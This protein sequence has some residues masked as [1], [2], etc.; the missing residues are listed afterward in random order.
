MNT[1]FILSSSAISIG[2]IH[3]L[4]G[5]DHYLPF[6]VMAKA[7]QW[8]LMKTTLITFF[9]GV[10]H[11]LSA[12]I[13]GF[14]AISL[15]AALTHLKWIESLRGEIA[16]WLLIGFGL[17]YFIWGIKHAIKH[18]RH[19]H[20]HDESDGHHHKKSMRE[21]TPWI[22]FIIFILGPCE[23]LIPLVMYPAIKGSYLGV[24]A[25]SICFGLATLSVML[26][27]VLASVTGM[28]KIKFK[29]FAKYGHVMAG[30]I[31]CGSGLAIKFLG[32]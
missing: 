23:P 20:S 26:S 6:I 24:A 17:A 1:L 11:V 4:L 18:G 32:L 2:F 12:V 13:L 9:C 16:A 7:R 30:S 15:G 21:L 25:V 3:T 29:L 22:L 14:V 31:V 10:G 27:L 19:Q 8:S 28:E 5:P